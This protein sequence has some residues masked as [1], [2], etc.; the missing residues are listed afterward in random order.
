MICSNCGFK[1]NDDMRICP[2]CG[3]KI[4]NE[5]IK[6]MNK[7]KVKKTIKFSLTLVL[8]ILC[9][10]VSLFIMFVGAIG[11]SEGDLFFG[12]SIILFG[13]SLNPYLY[14]KTT[15]KFLI[16]L[17]PIIMFVLAFVVALITL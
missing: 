6:E 14:K 12:I 15:H 7:Q 10:L 13:L 2:V 5:H 1:L 3:A 8:D 11:I 17:M 9:L 16:V 4:K